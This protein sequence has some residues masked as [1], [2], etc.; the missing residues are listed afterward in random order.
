[1]QEILKHRRFF[2]F[3]GFTTRANKLVL[4]IGVMLLSFSLHSQELIEL[5]AYL[6]QI[7][8]ENQTQ[9][10]VDDESPQLSVSEVK[11]EIFD[12]KATFH[13]L[14]H[15]DSTSSIMHYSRMI[16]EIDQLT[17]LASRMERVRDQFND[18]NTFIIKIRS[19]SDIVKVN[20]LNADLLGNLPGLNRIYF[21]VGFKATSTDLNA[22]SK[23]LPKQKK[24]SKAKTPILEDASDG[25]QNI[26]YLYK[27]TMPG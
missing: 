5:D 21:M 20:S 23:F 3:G 14:D 2:L 26:V 4:I 13:M 9:K 24:T 15:E 10:V 11:S 18:V 7:Q 19:Q 17:T 16:I 6:V 1:M 25:Q 12:S 22:L 27:I 8:N